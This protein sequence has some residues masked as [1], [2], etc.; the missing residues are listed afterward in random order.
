MEISF[1]F[2]S[3]NNPD[4]V[5]NGGTP[6]FREMG[7]YVF[8][9]Y[10]KLFSIILL[11]Q[12]MNSSKFLVFVISTANRINL[13]KNKFRKFSMLFCLKIFVVIEKKFCILNNIC[14]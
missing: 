7:P 14:V 9:L 8:K 11:L 2:F 6:K 5:I 4:E 12:L 10:F 1:T 3:V 13:E